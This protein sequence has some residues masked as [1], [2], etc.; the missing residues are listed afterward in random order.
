MTH[1]SIPQG[2][3]LRWYRWDDEY[4]IH[5]GPSNDT[6][7]LSADA[8]RV[9][10]ALQLHGAQDESS[11]AEHCQLDTGALKPVLAA[12]AELDLVARC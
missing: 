6:H 3:D 10:E 12:L 1:W 7:R 4:V 11:L 8:G 9:I 5:H 2:A